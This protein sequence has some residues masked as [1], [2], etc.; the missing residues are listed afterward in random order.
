MTRPIAEYD[1]GRLIL[2][3]HLFRVGMNWVLG[4]EQELGLKGYNTEMGNNFKQDN[5]NS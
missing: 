3:N 1:L 5:T 2:M 4:L